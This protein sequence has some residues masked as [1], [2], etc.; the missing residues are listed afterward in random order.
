MTAA[1]LDFHGV[2]AVRR[3]PHPRP[4]DATLIALSRATDHSVAWLIIAAVGVTIDR[5][6]RTRWLAAAARIAA[7]EVSVRAIK[8]GPRRRRPAI[9]GHP[10]LAR[11]T[12]PLSFPSS[13][14]AAAVAAMSAF[15]GLLPRALLRSVAATTAFSRLY[16]GLHFPSDVAAGALLGRACARVTRA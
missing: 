4:I 1:E 10:P 13:H 16:L 2:A 12:S 15:D 6:R 11:M 3:L 9:A 8:R 14:T 7:V 5:R